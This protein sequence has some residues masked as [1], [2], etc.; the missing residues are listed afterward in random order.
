MS[1]SLS[2]I[3]EHFYKWESETPD[4]DFL[5]QPFG[6][7]WTVTSYREAGQE[8]RKIASALKAKGLKAGDHVG[9]FSKNCMHWV[10]A[11]LAIMIAGMVSVPYY[12]SLP[13]DQLKEVIELSDIKA[14]FI[15][16]LDKWGDRD[17]ALSDQL[18]VIR[19]PHYDGD[20]DVSVGDSWDDLLASN[21]ALEENFTPDLESNWTIKFTSGTTGTP[22]G[23]MHTHKNPIL[24]LHNERESNWIGLFHMR[25]K[26]FFSFLPLNHVGERM[27]VEVPAIIAGG[28]ISFAQNLASFANNIK[29]TQPSML[30]A[31]PRIWTKFYQGVTAKIPEKKLDFYL[32]IPIVSGFVKKKLR[33]AMGLRDIEIAATGAAITPA[34]IKNFFAKLDIHL[35]EAYGMTET[36]GSITNTPDSCSPSDSVGRAIPGAE[37]RIDENTDEIMMRTP[38]MMAGYYNKPDKTAEVLNDGWLHSGD[39]GEIDEQG[40]LRVTGRVKDAFKTS[41]GSFVTPNPL[42]EVISGNEFVEQVCVVGLGIAQ[43]IALVNLGEAAEGHSKPEIADSL[44]DTVNTLNATRAKFEHVSTLVIHNEQWTDQNGF[45]TPTLKVKRTELDKAFGRQYLE[46]HEAPENVIWA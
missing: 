31:V 25:E 32:K 42:E 29:D 41:K 4:S 20:P 1:E 44:L 13:K 26:R 19:F 15:G 46:W 34:F 14:L 8:A 2:S 33:T 30:F 27:A 7:N 10:L 21:P 17:Q 12:A 5:R 45:L 23:V 28:S 37:I 22:K 18:Q 24:M 39:C 6:D 9:I 36:C 3:I 11:D 16:R 38:Y 43:P 40:F 35:I